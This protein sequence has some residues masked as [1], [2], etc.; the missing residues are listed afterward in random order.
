[1]NFEEVNL[2][3]LKTIWK[4]WLLL[5]YQKVFDTKLQMTRI[6]T[7][8]QKAAK[9]VILFYIWHNL[10]I[11]LQRFVYFC[12]IFPMSSVITEQLTQVNQWILRHSLTFAPDGFSAINY[13]KSI[14][15][16]L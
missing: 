14:W 6:Y 2:L 5:R 16:K 11:Y 10:G 9:V 3:F 12:H 4:N 1:M 13:L 8:M 7:K 15:E